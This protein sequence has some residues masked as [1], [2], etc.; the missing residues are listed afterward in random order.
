MANELT[1][2]TETTGTDT[3]R[4]QIIEIC[5]QIGFRDEAKIITKRI[6]PT[7]PISKEAQ[8]VHGISMED[9]KDSP[10]FKQVGDSLRGYF[11]Q[12]EVI[13]GYNVIFD[14]Q[15]M[16]AELLRNKLSPISLKGKLIIDPLQIWRK[17]KPRSLSHAVKEF[18]GRDHSTAHSA[19]G[20]VVATADV[21]QAMIKSFNLEN[22]PIKELAA[23]SLPQDWIGISN[24]ITWRKQTPVFNFGKGRGQPVWNYL[25][26]ESGYFDWMRRQNFPAHVIEICDMA[27]QNNEADFAGWVQENFA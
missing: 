14:L 11:D 20:D 18:C 7:I 21:Y 13:I 5:I 4:D 23:M 2:D 8:A 9:L 19:E 10:S 26:S 25:R 17:M 27:I 16:Q 1:F 24:H 22:T 6:K 12:A 15:I 3:S